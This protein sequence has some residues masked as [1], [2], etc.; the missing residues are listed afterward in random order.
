MSKKEEILGEG[1]ETAVETAQPVETKKVKEFTEEDAKVLAAGIAKVKQFGVSE[2]LSF[3]IDVLVPQW[4][5]GSDS[6]ELK[7]AK[8]KVTEHF[9][10]SD[11]FKDYIDDEF[12]K[13][14][15]GILGT[16]KVGAVLNNIKSFY[17]RRAGTT[18]KAPVMKVRIGGILYATDKEYYDSVATKSPE[19]KKEL[20]LA[21]P[22][23]KP[24]EENII[25][26]L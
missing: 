8:E 22:S 26:I 1:L 23:T 10:G 4:P 15:D 5:K 2:N 21:H 16:Q 11:K 24:V 3:V 14:L 12:Q 13:E 6:E 20:L 17:A 19:E 25:D 9:G 7:S 18:K